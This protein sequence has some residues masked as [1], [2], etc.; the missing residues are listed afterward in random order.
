M[1]FNE[2]SFNEG[3]RQLQLVHVKLI[4][5]NHAKKLIQGILKPCMKFNGTS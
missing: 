5:I 1:Q 2:F 4:E 3:T